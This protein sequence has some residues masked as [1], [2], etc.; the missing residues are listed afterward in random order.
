MPTGAPAGAVPPLIYRIN[1]AN[2]LVWV[3]E[4]WTEAAR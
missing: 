4:A 2:R 3:N 1:G